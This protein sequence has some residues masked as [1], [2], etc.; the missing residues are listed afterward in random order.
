M[1]I[2]KRTAE[3][4][5]KRLR[6][7]DRRARG[8]LWQLLQQRASQIL[9]RAP[10]GSPAQL[11]LEESL[12]NA[13]MVILRRVEQ[14]GFLTGNF[15]AFCTEVLKRCCWDQRR[16]DRRHKHGEL[17]LCLPAA[18]DLPRARSWRELC[19]M[20][21][22]DDLLRWLL[23]LRHQDRQLLDLN[24]QGYGHREIAELSGLSYGTVR[25]RYAQLIKEAARRCAV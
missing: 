19:Q 20:S 16:K 18:E 25:N 17:P 8:L 1:T 7:G 22:R 14:G 4:L 13:F 23:G 11:Q 3:G 24:L 21:G 12:S 10:M 5:P 15:T 6:S 9:C 2:D